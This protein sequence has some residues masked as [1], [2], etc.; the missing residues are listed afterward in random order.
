MVFMG[1]RKKFTFISTRF[2]PSKL[3]TFATKSAANMEI[4]KLYL[5]KK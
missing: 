3:K 2:L 4:I 5:K 1:E